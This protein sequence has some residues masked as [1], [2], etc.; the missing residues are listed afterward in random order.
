MKHAPAPWEVFRSGQGNFWVTGLPTPDGSAGIAEISTLITR[1]Y[2]E[3]I[4]NAYLIAA[5]PDLLEACKGLL[6]ILTPKH[7]SKQQ[8]S[9]I[10]RKAKVAIAKAEIGEKIG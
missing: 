6:G 7:Y 9:D 8:L 1:G 10:Y 4:A 3:T 2:G 5:A